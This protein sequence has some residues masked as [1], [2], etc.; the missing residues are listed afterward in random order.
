MAGDR[1]LIRAIAIGWILAAAP[2]AHAALAAQEPPRPPSDSELV[3]L[4]RLLQG[5]RVHGRRGSR[6]RTAADRGSDRAAVSAE[7]NQR[8]AQR[9]SPARR[10]ARRGDRSRAQV[11]PEG[12]G[13]HRH[14]RRPHSHRRPAAARSTMGNPGR[15][16]SYN[17][18]V[19]D[20]SGWRQL[21]RRVPVLGEQ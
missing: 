18:A 10:P 1:A 5:P 3:S 7:R 4:R 2:G 16:T 13:R 21:R 15:D 12:P 8:R 17:V 19:L 9:H 6:A 20:V 14:R 11:G